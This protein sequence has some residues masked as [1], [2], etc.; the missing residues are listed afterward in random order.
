MNFDFRAPLLAR[1]AAPTLCAALMFAAFHAADVQAELTVVENA[2]N[3]QGLTVFK[4]TVTPAAE[5]TPALK[6]RLMPKV[7]EM[8]PGNAA[9]YYTRAFAEHG[10]AGRWKDI[11][12][13]HGEEEVNGG[14]GKAA[15]YSPAR[16]FTTM[17]MDKAREASA[18]FDVIV[19]QCVARGTV[20]EN[21]DWGRNIEELEGLDI[22]SMLLPEVQETRE[23][24]RMLMLRTRMA[25][26]DGDYD[27]A[28][29]H[30]RM[31]YRLGQ[32][33]ASDPIL[34]CGL[35]GIAEAALGNYELPE[36]IAA[37]NSPNLYWALAELPRP[38]IDL[39]PA[40][41][42]ELSWGMK[43]FPVLIDPEKQ[44]HSPQEWARLL[45]NSLRDMQLAA[46]GTPKLDDWAWRLG[47][48]GFG[49]AAYPDA[50]QRLLAAGMDAAEIE[51][52]PTGQVIAVDASREY[53]RVAQEFEKWWYTPYS[54]AKKR[55]ADPDEFLRDR[56]GGG[57]GRILA[58]L[59]MP[60][61]SRV[62]DAQM[63]LDWQLNALQAIEAIR[64]HAAETG[65]LP[66]SLQEI[67][68]V[69]V[70]KNPAT[71][72]DYQYRLDGDTAILELPQSDGFTGV[73]WR[74]EITLAK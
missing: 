42:Y 57:Y 21:C 72:Q 14:G 26:A 66:Q 35:V 23:L 28:I 17:P 58:S 8:R 11:L 7:L 18:A 37:K 52:M 22:I 4:M 39:Y 59:L 24:S 73:A 13:A 61:L 63:R 3:Q 9:M 2:D 16:P 29:D 56:F 15:W 49:L 68:I 53:Q 41:R 33:V 71:E 64:M 44:E 70:P 34:I 46:D 65:K 54:V 36:L 31:N 5:P 69:P 1:P 45:A 48:V 43:I 12:K 74:Y 19:E 30:L 51:R 40:T 60:A 10:V 6:Y 27:R 62:R 38:F 25:I 67:T 47:V 20:R 32:N 55:G 50:K